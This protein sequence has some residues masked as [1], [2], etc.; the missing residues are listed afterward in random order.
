MKKPVLIFDWDGTIADSMDLCVEEVRQSLQQLGLPP[1]SLELM[2][3]C[4]GPTFE[5]T[6]PM[7]GVPEHLAQRY[8]ELRQEF[9]LT[10]CETVNHL[11]PGIREMLL[12]LKEKAVL[13]IASNGTGEYIAHCCEVF[14]TQGIFTQI[15]ASK[16]GRS[17]A[18]AVAEILAAHQGAQA[19]MIGDRLGDLNAGKANGLP[20]ICCTFG[21][22]NEA[23]WAQADRLAHTTQELEALLEEFLTHGHQP[24]RWTHGE[25]TDFTDWL[26]TDGN[27][28]NASDGGVIYV[29]GVY[30]WY[31]MAFRPLPFAGKGQGG[32]ATTTG[33]VMYASRDLMTWT[34]E[35][36]I[37]PCSTD[38]ADDLY[39]PMRFERPK[40]IYNDRTKQF[41]LWC[42]YV[43]HPG[44]H[45]FTP[46][47]ADAGVA[48]CDTVNGQYRW[49]GYKRPID[50]RGFVR[51]CTLFKDQDGS[52]YFIYDR[53]VG[54]DFAGDRCQ[55]IVKLTE[56]Y[57]DFTQE[58][59]RL[60]AAYWREAAAVVHHGG[61]YYMITSDLTSWAFNQAK[62][63]R[64]PSIWGPWEDMGDP[65]I[66]DEDHTTF[67][68]QTTNI[69][70][71]EGR[72]N[73]FIHM[74][75]RHN[76]KNFLHSSYVWL[77][78]QFLPGG[79][80][81]LSYRKEITL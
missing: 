67:H 64:A 46:G 2:R 45:G 49:L 66:G 53:H 13:C 10:L 32:Q 14:G 63:F 80:L 77:P 74:A 75:E 6:V 27:V 37:L 41:V 72:E 47:T 24:I 40:I 5:E 12:R 61:Y 59:M 33:V 68:S 1:V 69:F 22:G 31:G 29:D 76:T 3:A 15:E 51:D 19:I 26:D 30:H 39:G 56:D 35:G 42:H 9:G 73:L 38:P 23:E 62:Y 70:R 52:A 48:V 17:K 4:N 58:S 34:Y 43:K 7:L 44:D 81:Q 55:Y 79:R 20:T 71:V 16:P 54:E 21:Y 65:C 78:I 18:Q 28:I 57:L 50:D 60:D 11:F 25:L 36:V 8:M